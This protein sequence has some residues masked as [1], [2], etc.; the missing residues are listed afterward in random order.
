MVFNFCN[1]H[2]ELHLNK[3]LISSICYCETEIC[4][5]PAPLFNVRLTDKEGNIKD[6]S[7]VD[8]KK[9]SV[10][11]LLE[12]SSAVSDAEKL[13]SSNCSQNTVMTSL[14]MNG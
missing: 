14:I 7:A 11:R 10:K 2:I 3:G 6:I 4:A 13:I 8:A 12:L 1:G 5:K 9:V